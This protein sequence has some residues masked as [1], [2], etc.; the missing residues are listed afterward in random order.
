MAGATSIP[1]LAF[2]IAVITWQPLQITPA[3]GL[4]PSWITGLAMATHRGLDF[5]TQVIFTYGPLGFLRHQLV[6]YG[7]LAVLSTV[8]V[9]AVRVGLAAAVLWAVRRRLPLWVAIIVALGASLIV[10]PDAIVVIVF[11]CCAAA[12]WEDPPKRAAS[13]VAYGGA[14]VSAVEVLVKLNTGFLVLALCLVATLVLEGNRLRNLLRFGATFLAAFAALWFATG[15]G[16][17]NL[18]DYLR[19]AFEVISGFSGAMSLSAGRGWTLAAAAVVICATVGAWILAVWRLPRP[20]AGGL[21]ALVVILCFLA[22]KAGF[23][24]QDAGHIEFFFS[25]MIAPWIALIWVRGWGRI[26]G[27]AGFGVM[28]VL[29][30]AGT[31][32]FPAH[33]GYLTADLDPVHNA[34]AA[35][36]NVHDLLDP[37]ARSAERDLARQALVDQYRLDPKTLRM[38]GDQ[39]V[40]VYPSEASLAWAYGLNW[41]PLPV[42]Q[43]YTAYTPLL[44]H[45]NANALTS[46][47]GPR[48]ILRQPI[49]SLDGRYPPYDT[50][51]A[52]LAMLCNFKALRTT[53]RFQLLGRVADRCGASHEISSVSADYGQTVQVPR[54]LRSGEAVFARVSGL[55]PSGIEQLRALLL[56]PAVRGLVFDGQWKYRFI[57]AVA[58][59]GLI[60]STPR[61][62]DFGA[63][64]FESSTFSWKLA[65]RPN[66]T[67]LSFNKNSGITSPD[68]PLRIDFYTMAVRPAR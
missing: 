6:M 2:V 55:M 38:I 31:G 14:L 65:P 20:Q 28:V 62:A 16:I 15:Q 60:L 19:T 4:D 45:Q 68:N 9:V 10:T 56:R 3:A 57:P 11:L 42:F 27:L 41:D 29:F 22:W 44:D 5:G 63:P 25:W 1:V 50:P 67:T 23:V 35:V 49:G 47:D 53:S 33:D 17:G 40:D 30:Y 26:A 46:A 21:V 24:R 7:D 12:I 18:D 66:A 36:N 51:A 59:D 58:G 64:H 32:F 13:L 52:T 43:T 39:P 34:K 48:L 8:Y 54:A 37:G 61:S